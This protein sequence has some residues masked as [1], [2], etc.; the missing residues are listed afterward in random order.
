MKKRLVSIMLCA[1]VLIGTYAASIIMP[2]SAATE[3]NDSE[4]IYCNATLNDDYA[5]DS[6]LVVMNTLTSL[7]FHTYSAADFSEIKA[8]NVSHITA[9]SES[10]V[11]KALN[12]AETAAACGSTIVEVEP[13]DLSTYRQVLYV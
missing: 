10:V 4:R 9:Y 13:V 3:A 6:V 2:V 7:K 1:I 5:P 12:S 8:K 11:Q